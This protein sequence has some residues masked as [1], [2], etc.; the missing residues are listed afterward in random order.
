M[1]E[2]TEFAL[3]T[4]AK[5]LVKHTDTMTSDKRY[6]KKYR[7]TLVTR[8][9]D[10]TLDVFEC[11]QEANELDLND[12]EESRERL[13]LQRRAMTLC[14]TVLFLIEV[15]HEKNLIS[16]DQCGAWTKYVLDVKN[17]AANWYRKDKSRAKL[18]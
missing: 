3:I 11:I 18:K 12:P 2:Q 7:F 13:R 16:G 15:S 6:P 1:A 8:L 5:N 4:K 10:K 9:Q 14:K 17:M